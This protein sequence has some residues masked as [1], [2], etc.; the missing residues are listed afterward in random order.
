MNF[1]PLNAKKLQ[2]SIYET[3]PSVIPHTA[4]ATDDKT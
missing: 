4:D 2:L 3:I 1:L